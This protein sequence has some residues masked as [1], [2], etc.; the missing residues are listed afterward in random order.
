MIARVQYTLCC[1]ILFIFIFIFLIA[2]FLGVVLL[3]DTIYL[4]GGSRGHL[5][6]TCTVNNLTHVHREYGGFKSGGYE[7]MPLMLAYHVPSKIWRRLYD[8]PIS[9]SH[10]EG[11]TIVHR[12]N[13]LTFG[14]TTTGDRLFSEV[15][16]YL[17]CVFIDVYNAC[18]RVIPS[19][20]ALILLNNH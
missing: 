20:G 7:H 18:S 2:I 3:N 19:A 17:F 1:I 6:R 10:T 13:I 4:V 15:Y 5:D 8:P 9:L 16:W 11:S 14:G 12:G